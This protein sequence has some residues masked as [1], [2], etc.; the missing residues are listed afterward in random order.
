MA[1]RLVYFDNAA[2]T[3]RP[4]I[5]AHDLVAYADQFG[6]GPGGPHCNQISIRK[7]GFR[8]TARVG[9][10]IY[11]TVQ[12]ISFWHR[13]RSEI[14]FADGFGRTLRRDHPG[15]FKA[16]EKFRP[17]SAACYAWRGL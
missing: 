6:I 15:L 12:E 2:S 1:N 9:L 5:H 4:E 16:A 14:F 13:R 3:W 17:T 8:A 11:T 7:L 10:Y